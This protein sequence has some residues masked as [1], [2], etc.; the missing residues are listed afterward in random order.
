ME[1]NK[2]RNNNNL[3]LDPELVRRSMEWDEDAF[4][5]VYEATH[6]RLLRIVRKYVKNAVPGDAVKEDGKTEAKPTKE[7]LEQVLREAHIRIWKELPT[8]DRP[9][10]Y[11]SWAERI[12]AE[13][14]KGMGQK[15][16]GMSSQGTLPQ[17]MPSQG[18]LPQ[19]MQP[20]GTPEQGRPK[21]NRSNAFSKMAAERGMSTQSGSSEEG[22]GEQSSR[23]RSG[24]KKIKKPERDPE[25]PMD[26]EKTEDPEKVGSFLKT[27]GGKIA[28]GAA[29]VVIAASVLLGIYMLIHALVHRSDPEPSEQAETASALEAPIQVSVTVNSETTEGISS[30]KDTEAITEPKTESVTEKPTEKSTEIKDP[31]A[32]GW[33]EIN[34]RRYYYDAKGNLK[35]GWIEDNGKWYFLSSAGEITTGWKKIRG[36]DYFFDET[37]VMSTGTVTIEGQEYT[38]DDQG[39]LISGGDTAD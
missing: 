25:Q 18:T 9:E 34:G 27:V 3:P 11:M 16:Q 26:Q 14:A 7:R 12:V 22:A 35:T 10:N 2:N 17:G 15:A 38:F 5:Q 13:T 33:Q 28:I 23:K 30:E 4:Q 31:H 36:K 6:D 39:A 29:G 1:T 37:G 8:L 24:T 32:P 20:Q 19:G 21:K